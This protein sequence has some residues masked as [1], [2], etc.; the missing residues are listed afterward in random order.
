MESSLEICRADKKKW[1]T[2]FLK[3]ESSAPIIDVF[4]D[5]SQ[6]D[7]KGQILLQGGRIE[8]PDLLDP[9]AKGV[10]LDGKLNYFKLTDKVSSKV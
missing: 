4:K 10:K 7:H 6:H 2:K 8:I 5:A 9:D 3:M 1:T